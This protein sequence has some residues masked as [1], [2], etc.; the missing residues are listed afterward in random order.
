MCEPKMQHKMSS[1]FWESRCSP[2]EHQLCQKRKWRRW[3]NQQLSWQRLD[4]SKCWRILCNH[5]FVSL[6]RS[7]HPSWH[8]QYPTNNSK[9]I[10][11][12]TL[13]T[14]TSA[15]MLFSILFLIHF[16]KCWQGE[17]HNQWW[18]SLVGDPSFILLTL[19]CDLRVIW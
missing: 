1:Q 7:Q 2:L 19:M 6:P 16:L 8:H 15:Y 17:F 18:A 12:L 4:L 11:Q 14:L 5:S 3:K 13:Y 9:E 10:K